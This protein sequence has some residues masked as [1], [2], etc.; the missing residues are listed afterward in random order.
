MHLYSKCYIG[1][2]NIAKIKILPFYLYFIFCIWDDALAI[3][4]LNLIWYVIGSTIIFNLAFEERISVQRVNKNIRP[5]N[6]KIQSNAKLSDNK[7]LTKRDG[8]NE[9]HYYA[10]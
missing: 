1:A 6:W 3:F 10:F 7:C 2:K 9:F 8:G 5:V 4:L